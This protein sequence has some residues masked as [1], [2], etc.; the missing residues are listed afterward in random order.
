[1]ISSNLFFSSSKAVK[2]PINSLNN[3]FIVFCEVVFMFICRPS[4]KWHPSHLPTSTRQRRRTSTISELLEYHWNK[5]KK[6]RTAI[7]CS[8][9]KF[10]SNDRK[11]FWCVGGQMRSIRAVLLFLRSCSS[12]R[13]KAKIIRSD[14]KRTLAAQLTAMAADIAAANPSQTTKW[15]RMEMGGRAN[16]ANTTNAIFKTDNKHEILHTH[17]HK[18]SIAVNVM[19]A[20]TS[21]I[22][23]TNV[24]ITF[25]LVLED[26]YGGRT[27]LR[28]FGPAHRVRVQ[29]VKSNSHPQQ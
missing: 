8:K 11:E 18:M 16:K 21:T 27:M 9:W 14:S 15:K 6:N 13:V 17:K 10:D 20:Q 28:P 7:L 23:A 29:S 2:I 25:E 1:M 4:I 12:Q 3:V 24:F 26:I 5:Q 22:H 19:N